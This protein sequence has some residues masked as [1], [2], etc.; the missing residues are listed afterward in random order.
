MM[1]TTF[2]RPVC[3]EDLPLLCE[4]SQSTF[5]ASHGHSATAKDIAIYLRYAYSQK[6]LELELNHPDTIFN[7]IYF[8]NELAGYS[9][10][11]LNTA[12]DD[13]D[14]NPL[15]KLDR[16]YLDTRYLGAELGQILFDHNLAI[17]KQN[18]Q[19]GIWLYTWIENHRAIHFYKK[20][21]FEIKDEK[22]F[23]ISKNHSNPNYIMYRKIN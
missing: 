22:E 9:K 18:N 6:K 3:L 11:I 21:G 7:F 4:L 13:I 23:K 1:Q 15:A 14:R 16:L 12:Y 2:I 17:A 8:Q 20:N 5:L 10:I 19:K